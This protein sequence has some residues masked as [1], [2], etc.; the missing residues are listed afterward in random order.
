[1]ETGINYAE[2]RKWHRCPWGWHRL[3]FPHHT[4]R[5]WQP[6]GYFNV[7]DRTVY[8]KG[9]WIYATTRQRARDALRE[10]CEWARPSNMETIG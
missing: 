2:D 8:R 7:S 1:M 6:A 10:R 9:G 5:K 4:W 3:I